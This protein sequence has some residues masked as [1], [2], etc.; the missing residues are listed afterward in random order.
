LGFGDECDFVK[1][2]K[3]V[4]IH[5]KFVDEKIDVGLYLGVE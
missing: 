3:G 1:E 4:S 2:D 5:G